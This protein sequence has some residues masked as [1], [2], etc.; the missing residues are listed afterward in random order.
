MVSN[1]V[2]LSVTC[3]A[4]TCHSSEPR[5]LMGWFICPGREA[6]CIRTNNL[7]RNLPCILFCPQCAHNNYPRLLRVLWGTHDHL[8]IH[9]LRCVCSA[10]RVVD[11]QY[12]VGTMYSGPIWGGGSMLVF[13]SYCLSLVFDVGCSCHSAY[14]TL[15]ISTNHS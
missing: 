8:Y 2:A 1:D 14:T 15:L 9:S 11:V 7:Y 12:V 5:V 3:S 4:L 6:N 10:H 13:F